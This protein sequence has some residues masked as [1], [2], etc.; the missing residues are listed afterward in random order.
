M[1]KTSDIL[2]ENLKMELDRL[3]WKDIDLAKATGLSRGGIYKILQGTKKGGREPSFDNL[4][5]I[6]KA[7]GHTTA[8]LLTDHSAEKEQFKHNPKEALLVLAEMVEGKMS[9]PKFKNVDEIFKFGADFMSDPTKKK[10][11]QASSTSPKTSVSKSA[12]LRRK[13]DNK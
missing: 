11:D 8:Y 1:R 4:D 12:A 2:I 13:S 3:H 6:A 5:R 7:I 10:N 9:L